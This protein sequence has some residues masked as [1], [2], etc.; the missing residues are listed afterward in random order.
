MAVAALYAAPEVQQEPWKAGR[1]GDVWSLGLTIWECCV[2][3]LPPPRMRELAT[4]TTPEVQ[5][6]VQALRARLAS[7][8]ANDAYLL[9]FFDLALIM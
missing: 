6:M 4:M 3:S 8:T 1:R 7:S 2:E 5:A 9:T